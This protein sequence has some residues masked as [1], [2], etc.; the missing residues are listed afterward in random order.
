MKLNEAFNSKLINKQI[1]P[2]ELKPQDGMWHPEE[3][4]SSYDMI[5]NSIYNTTHDEGGDEYED[6]DE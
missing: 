2:E 4:G 5:F 6:W 1:D 3:N